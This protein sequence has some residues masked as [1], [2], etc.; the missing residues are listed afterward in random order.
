MENCHDLL[1]GALKII[2][3]EEGEGLRVNVDT[4]LLAHFSRP[5][6][7]K[8]YWRSAAR[9]ARCRSSSQSGDSP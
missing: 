6:A 5:N 2:Q 4:V 1:R 8:K 3:P 7:V 9:T